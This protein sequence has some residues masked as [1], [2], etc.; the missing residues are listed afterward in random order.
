MILNNSNYHSV[1]EINVCEACDVEIGNRKK[2]NTVP[3]DLNVAG[4][5]DVQS[6]LKTTAKRSKTEKCPTCQKFLTVKRI[7][8]RILFVDVENQFSFLEKPHIEFSKITQRIRYGRRNFSLKSVIEFIPNQKH[9]IAHIKRNDGNWETFDDLSH[10][11]TRLIKANEATIIWVIFIVMRFI[12][13]K[14]V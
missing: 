2:H 9:F 1:D 10:L 11:V 7:P 14:K 5:T 12:Y 4:I 3:I 13:S 8:S 6:C